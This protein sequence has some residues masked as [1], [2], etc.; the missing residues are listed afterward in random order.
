MKTKNG[1]V[2]NS[3]STSFCIYGINMNLVDMVEKL[4][5][6][7]L[8]SEDE[9]QDLFSEDEIEDIDFWKIG[10]KIDME[11]YEY[12]EGEEAYIGKSWSSI[13]DDQTGREFKEEVERKL[14][15]IFG[16]NIKC[17]TFEEVL[18]N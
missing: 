1:F 8:F 2:S 7:N 9:I 14:N 16:N 11:I 6:F 5:S 15:E 18:E 17:G 10:K 13:K 12:Y 3:S 4:K